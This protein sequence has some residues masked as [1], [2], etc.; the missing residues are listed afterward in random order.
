MLLDHTT[1]GSAAHACVPHVTMQ[2]FL[3]KELP[4][5]QLA[6]W[7]RPCCMNMNAAVHLNMNVQ[8]SCTAYHHSH[9]VGPTVQLCTR[10][11]AT[12]VDAAKNIRHPLCP[13]KCTQ[14]ITTHTKR[15]PVPTG[16]AIS[17][18][19]DLIQSLNKVR[20]TSVRWSL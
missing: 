3:A 5:R 17:Y 14:Q 10:G 6:D 9:L 4:R 1:L 12:C 19:P 16:A 20:P 18:Y 11:A 15:D 8:S 2:S 7:Y 13:S